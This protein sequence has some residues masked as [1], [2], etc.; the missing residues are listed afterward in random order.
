MRKMAEIMR[1]VDYLYSG[2]IGDDNF[3]KR[4]KEIEEKYAE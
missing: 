4:I 2:D 3:F 1:I